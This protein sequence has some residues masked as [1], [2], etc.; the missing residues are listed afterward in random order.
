MLIVIQNTETNGPKSLFNVK[1]NKAIS[2]KR[3]KIWLEKRPVVIRL[4][5]TETLN[6]SERM[7]KE[8][9]NIVEEY[10]ELSYFI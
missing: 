1:K 7:I 5:R 9:K 3:K 6:K 10:M 8:K 2:K 4:Q